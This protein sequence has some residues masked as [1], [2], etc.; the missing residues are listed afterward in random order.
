MPLKITSPRA[1]RS[2]ANRSAIPEPYGVGWRVPT[3]AIPGWEI[4]ASLPRT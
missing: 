2:Q 1:A 3:N 4:T